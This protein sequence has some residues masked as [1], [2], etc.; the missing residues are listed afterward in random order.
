MKLEEQVCSLELA[1]RLKELGVKQESYFYWANLDDDECIICVL[2][3]EENSLLWQLFD[4]PLWEY[5][6]SLKLQFERINEHRR[7]VKNKYTPIIK[8]ELRK[9]FASAFTVAELGEMLPQVINWKGEP[10]GF[11]GIRIDETML[12]KKRRYRVTYEDFNSDDIENGMNFVE[13]T[14]ADARAKMLIY[15]IENK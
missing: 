6:K 12:S 5:T 13:D 2:E 4:V 15:L 1:K 7:I 11:L 10:F 8:R 14:E 3:R 9:D